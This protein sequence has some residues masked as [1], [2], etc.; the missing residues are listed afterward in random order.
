MIKINGNKKT[1]KMMKN[2]SRK[3][4]NKAKKIKKIKIWTMKYKIKTNKKKIKVI[5]K[6]QIMRTIIIT[7]NKGHK[8]YKYSMKKENKHI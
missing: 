6:I 8:F 4:T 3:K 1:T 7:M 2:K 5:N